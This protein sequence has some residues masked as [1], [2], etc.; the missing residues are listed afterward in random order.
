MTNTIFSEELSNKIVNDL[1]NEAKNMKK[2]SEPNRDILKK[3]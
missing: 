2:R 1:I 3:K